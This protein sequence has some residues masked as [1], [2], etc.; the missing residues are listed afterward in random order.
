MFEL[1]GGRDM[2]VSCV[3]RVL[4]SLGVT[5]ESLRIWRFFPLRLCQCMLLFIFAY[6]MLDSISSSHPLADRRML[7]FFGKPSVARERRAERGARCPRRRGGSEILD[8][9]T[10]PGARVA[11]NHDKAALP[12]RYPFLALFS[13]MT[14]RY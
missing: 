7:F 2:M 12:P 4:Q 5:L 6:G 8:G 3:R 9:R 11:D 1:R 14:C 10:R 13:A